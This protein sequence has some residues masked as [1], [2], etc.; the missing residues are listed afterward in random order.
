MEPS[1]NQHLSAGL[2]WCGLPGLALQAI[3]C[4]ISP[5]SESPAYPLP[6][7]TRTGCPLKGQIWAAPLLQR[8]DASLGSYTS[9]SYKNTDVSSEPLEGIPDDGI[10]VEKRKPP[11]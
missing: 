9:I 8:G 1:S 3:R 7:G 4:C 6:F 10:C 11:K 2:G 5:N